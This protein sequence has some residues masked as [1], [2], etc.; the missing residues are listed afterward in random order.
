MAL[1]SRQQL[2]VESVPARTRPG[3]IRADPTV[4]KPL[5]WMS[6]STVAAAGLDSRLIEN[7]EVAAA[8]PVA[9]AVIVGHAPGNRM[10]AVAEQRRVDLEVTDGAVR[11]RV[12]GERRLDVASRQ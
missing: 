3:N 12:A 10:H 6:N 4:V 5:D 11:V 1:S 7:G 9:V 2:A 8:D